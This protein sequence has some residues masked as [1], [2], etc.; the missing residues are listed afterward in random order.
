MHKIC[1]LRSNINRIN[2]WIHRKQC[3]V[4]KIVN[5]DQS[6][7]NIHPSHILRRP[8]ITGISL[9]IDYKSNF[10]IASIDQN[11]HTNR[12]TQNA[13]D[14]TNRN[15]FEIVFGPPKVLYVTNHTFYQ[16][17]KSTL[18]NI[19][20]FAFGNICNFWNMNNLSNWAQCVDIT[21]FEPLFQLTNLQNT[22]KYWIRL[23]CI[24]NEV[25][26]NCV[27]YDEVADGRYM[28]EWGMANEHDI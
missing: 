20:K 6:R 22:C 23:F 4:R 10:H 26:T 3:Y 13:N 24:S 5:S 11:K 1:F 9:K 21:R 16:T 2:G 27:R 28:R 18:N 12:L 8:T 19:N 7:P 14:K 17:P 15:V 25:D